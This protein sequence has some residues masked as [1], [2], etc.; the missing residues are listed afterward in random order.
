MEENIA[1]FEEKLKELVALGKKK[2][3]VLEYSG[4]Q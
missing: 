4:D 2:K 3:S 1:K